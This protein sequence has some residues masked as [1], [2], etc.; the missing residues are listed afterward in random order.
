MPRVCIFC[1]GRNVSREHVWPRWL[2]ESLSPAGEILATRRAAG[3][4]KPFK[5]TSI[6]LT[7]KVVCVRCNSGWMSSLEAKTEPL[8]RPIIGGH[9]AELNPSQQTVIAAWAT[10]TLMVGER[11]LGLRAGQIYWRRED[12][13]ELA[14]TLRVPG[15]TVVLIAA[16]EGPG[17][18]RIRAGTLE[19]AS[20]RGSAIGTRATLQVGSLVLQVDSNRYQETTGRRGFVWP[21]RH[22][23][24]S[25]WV[26]PTRNLI[27]RWPPALPLSHSELEEFDSG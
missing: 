10:K 4:T 11:T 5:A 26:F 22:Q 20:S 24:R 3:V 18:A 23:E 14:T 2:L 1:G 17:H 6:E 19:V 12:G 8:L 25:E 15:D 27:V 7:A 13:E 9:S 21:T 16:Y